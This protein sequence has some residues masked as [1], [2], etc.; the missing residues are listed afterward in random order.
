MTGRASLSPSA[1]PT[2]CQAADDD[3]EER[4]NG[5]DDSFQDACNSVHDCH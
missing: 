4:G 2:A 1:A 3:I 5:I